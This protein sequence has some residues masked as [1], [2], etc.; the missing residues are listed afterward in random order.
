MV[1][2]SEMPTG[3]TTRQRDDGT[4]M[5]CVALSAHSRPDTIR[6]NP[7]STHAALPRVFGVLGSTMARVGLSDCDPPNATIS[8]LGKL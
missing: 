2:L 1:S 7:H 4:T 6:C 8:R 3:P 5:R